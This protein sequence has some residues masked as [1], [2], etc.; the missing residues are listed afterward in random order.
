[1]S[2]FKDV[3]DPNESLKLIENIFFDINH[4]IEIDSCSI[5]DG[6]EYFHEDVKSNFKCNEVI[7]Y[8]VVNFLT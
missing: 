5:T 8:N 6:G 2:S 7:V 1:M 3:F 4:K